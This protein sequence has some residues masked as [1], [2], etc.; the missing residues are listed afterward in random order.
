MMPAEVSLRGEGCRLVLRV[1]RY[2]YPAVTSGS[3]AN[4]LAGEVVLPAGA[5]GAYH[6]SHRVALRTDELA[7][8]R[9]RAACAGAGRDRR[10]VLRAPRGAGRHHRPPERGQA[11][12][13]RSSCASTSAPSSLPGRPGSASRRSPDAL[14]ELEV[15]VAAYP[16]AATPTTSFPASLLD[17]HAGRDREPPLRA[18][19]HTVTRSPVTSASLGV[20]T[21]PRAI[22]ASPRARASATVDALR[23][24]AADDARRAHA[25]ESRLRAAHAPGQDP[26][27]PQPARRHRRRALRGRQAAAL[28]SSS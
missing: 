3:D 25:Q 7:E 12:R 28:A 11:P 5:T 9:D 10:G 8:F 27:Q 26:G 2:A 17:A 6:A 1:D 15:V 24:A 20:L 22:A 19:A 18:V 13:F 21:A 16:V 14:A 23:P 4:W